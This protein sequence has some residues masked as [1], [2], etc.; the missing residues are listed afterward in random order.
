MVAEKVTG[1]IQPVHE[2][3]RQNLGSMG[4]TTSEDISSELVEHLKIV[5]EEVL[6]E[7]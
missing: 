3:V 2:K 1:I 7:T 4:M 6:Q 5:E